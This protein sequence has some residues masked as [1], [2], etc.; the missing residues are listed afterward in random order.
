M[1]EVGE[2]R[3]L[4]SSRRRYSRRPVNGAQ[5]HGSRADGVAPPQLTPPEILGRLGLAGAPPR[6]Q[7]RTVAELA[8]GGRLPLGWLTVMRQAGWLPYDVDKDS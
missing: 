2:A 7:R 8:F 6:E 4:L 5:D 3:I 1:T